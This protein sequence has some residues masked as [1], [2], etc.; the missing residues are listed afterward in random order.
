MQA[1]E[2]LSRADGRGVQFKRY[3]E[4]NFFKRLSEAHKENVITYLRPWLR[5]LDTIQELPVR[6]LRKAPLPPARDDYNLLR[7]QED[8]S[9]DR[10][11]SGTPPM[12]KWAV[13][14][15]RYLLPQHYDC[16]LA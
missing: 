8:L 13:E 2:P 15:I 1:I 16:L 10:T 9:Q 14:I 11:H 4:N 7:F 3:V 5:R 6:R 12:E